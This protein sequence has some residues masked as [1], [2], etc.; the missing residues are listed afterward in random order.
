MTPV[1]PVG[2]KVLFSIP[3]CVDSDPSGVCQ[4]VCVCVVCVCVY[5]CVCLLCVYVCVWYT[6]LIFD[7]TESTSTS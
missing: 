3:L 7:K 4:C 2:H 6:S 1:N 5:V